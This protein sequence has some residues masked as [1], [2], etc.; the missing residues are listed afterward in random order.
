MCIRDRSYRFTIYKTVG[1]NSYFIDE[2]QNFSAIHYILIKHKFIGL[3]E[4][5]LRA[6]NYYSSIFV[7]NTRLTAYCASVNS[8][9]LRKII[10]YICRSNLRNFAMPLNKRNLFYCIGTE[11]RNSLNH[12]ILKT[13]Y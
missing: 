12:L 11:C 3:A 7:K 6:G 8:E 2:P 5:L 9:E 13:F 1:I 10:G 4:H